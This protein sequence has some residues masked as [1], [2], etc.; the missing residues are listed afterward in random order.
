MITR[1]LTIFLWFILS[2]MCGSVFFD[3]LRAIRHNRNNRTF[4]VAL[5]DFLFWI[6]IG[7]IFLSFAYMLD[8][9]SIRFYMFIG[10]FLGACLYFLTFGKYVYK[11]LNFVCRYI[12][13][14]MGNIT[15]WMKG[16]D[17]EKESE[18]A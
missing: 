2:G 13:D 9:K 16:A 1:E 4:T 5:E 8:V 10:M 11:L 7:G 6:L 17:N 12:R 15:K 3:L 14:I 18:P